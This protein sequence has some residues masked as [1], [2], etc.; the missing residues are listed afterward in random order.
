NLQT[1]DISRNKISEQYPK[2]QFFRQF[3]RGVSS[4]FLPNQYLLR[5]TIFL[6]SNWILMLSANLREGRVQ[7]VLLT[8]GG[9]RAFI[10]T[11][12]FCDDETSKTII[13]RDKSLLG[14]TRRQFDW[15]WGDRKS[16]SL[17]LE[18]KLWYSSC[19]ATM[20]GRWSEVFCGRKGDF[21]ENQ[22]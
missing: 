5:E 10:G 7:S 16:E 22:A 13:F 14:K 6:E 20:E 8:M 12:E 4:E 17:G 2:K 9:D 21:E 15:E 11:K 19:K 18:E 1:L 3:F